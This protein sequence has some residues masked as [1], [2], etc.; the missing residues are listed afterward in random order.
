MGAAKH[1]TRRPPLK[2]INKTQDKTK[3]ELQQHLAFSKTIQLGFLVDSMG[4]THSVYA[5]FAIAILSGFHWSLL[6]YNYDYFSVCSVIDGEQYVHMRL[7]SKAFRAI[8]FLGFCFISIVSPN[9]KHYRAKLS[10]LA[11]A[12]WKRATT[13]YNKYHLCGLFSCC[14]SFFFLL[15]SLLW[16]KGSWAN[17]QTYV[18]EYF[19][20]LVESTLPSPLEIQQTKKKKIY[21]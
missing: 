8:V 11:E 16:L 10:L 20:F 19:V 9:E 12:K 17:M 5:R 18:M 4:W 13:A 2:T 14:C 15:L 1:T 7:I 21:W 6:T 3:N